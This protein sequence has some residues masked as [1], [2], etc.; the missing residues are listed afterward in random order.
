MAETST[1]LL[2]RL[3]SADRPEDWSRLNDLYAPLLRSWMRRYEVGDSDAADLIQ[4]VLMAVAKDVAKFEHNG[5]RGAFRTWLKRI[6]INRLRDFWK[7]QAKLPKATGGSDVVERLQQLD[8]PR[9][10]LS[11]LWDS[12]HDKHVLKKILD[13]AQPQFAPN[14]WEAFRRVVIERIP[15]EKVAEECGMTLNAV[16]IAKSRVVSRLRQ[17]ASGLVEAS[18]DFF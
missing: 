6:L 18:S 7:A 17:E 8:D 5:R 11:Q 13:A 10:A 3:R 12:E 1:S 14:T 9:S 4:E 2:E 15:V 16:F